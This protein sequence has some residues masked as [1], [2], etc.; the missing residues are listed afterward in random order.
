M[1]IW[2]LRNTENTFFDFEKK[3]LDETVISGFFHELEISKEQHLFET[4]I[5]WNIIKV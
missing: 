3:R 5:F 4:E 2:C 1:Q